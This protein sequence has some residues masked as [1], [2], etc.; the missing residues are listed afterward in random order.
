MSNSPGAATHTH[1]PSSVTPDGVF[2]TSSSKDGQ[3]MLRNGATGDWI[4][5]FLG[6]KGATWACALD[7]RAVRA[8]TASADFS[9]RVWDAVTG[10]EL[11]ALPHAHI[12][13]AV[14]FAPDGG[15]L[16]T[17]GYEKIVR[18]FDVSTLPGGGARPPPDGAPPPPHA[19]AATAPDKLRSLAFDAGGGGGSPASPL[20]YSA[21]MDAPGVA[22]WDLRAGTTV[23]TLATAAPAVSV[24]VCADGKHVVTAAGDTAALWSAAER[25]VVREFKTGAGVESA[26][27]APDGATMVVGGE[28]M[29]VH[30]L[31][32]ATGAELA[33]APLRGHHGPVHTVRWH[34]DGGSFASGSE[35]GTI[36][37][38][39]LEDEVEAD[40]AAAAAAE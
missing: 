3:S 38:W 23:A 16:V 37:I 32:A 9:A 14:A 35:D 10:D 24:E 21:F 39:T 25:R 33:G 30:V 8:A 15:S 34:P 2:L 7:A 18:V 29:W 4:G 26:S 31:D 19:V 40:D 36:R 13:R 17:G 6:H 27:L 20:L 22:V 1:T 12:V 11:A 5:T 28:D